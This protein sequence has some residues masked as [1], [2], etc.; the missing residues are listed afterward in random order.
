MNAKHVLVSVAIGFSML[1]IGCSQKA[2]SPGPIQKCGD[3]KILEEVIGIMS[4]VNANYPIEN[5]RPDLRMKEDLG[6][7]GKARMQIRMDLENDFGIKI[8]PEEIEKARTVEEL[9]AFVE[10]KVAAKK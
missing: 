1:L 3:K 8:Y 2:A 9:A 6:V 4:H 5:M 10:K 7:D